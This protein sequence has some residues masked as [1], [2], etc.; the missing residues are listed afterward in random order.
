MRLKEG[1]KI[2]LQREISQN[3]LQVVYRRFIAGFLQAFA[4]YLLS[5]S[6]VLCHFH[7]IFAVGKKTLRMDGRTNGQTD[8]PTDGQMDT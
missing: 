8:G 5:G 3:S 1:T 7:L 6:H 2:E 4:S